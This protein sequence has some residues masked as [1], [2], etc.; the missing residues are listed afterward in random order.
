MSYDCYLFFW[1][2]NTLPPYPV[3]MILQAL[4]TF[5]FS[6]DW[7]FVFMVW[8]LLPAPKGKIVG[9]EWLG[10]RALPQGSVFFEP[11]FLL[12]LIGL[13]SFSVPRPYSG[14]AATLWD[15]FSSSFPYFVHLLQPIHSVIPPWWERFWS[16]DIPHFT[17]SERN[18][19]PSLL[20]YFPSPWL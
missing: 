1:V 19:F 6:R 10:F 17:R 13:E 16:L 3:A 18:A 7:F 8:T 20:Q 2:K 4:F 11:C 9:D 15:S 14:M 5:L 12:S